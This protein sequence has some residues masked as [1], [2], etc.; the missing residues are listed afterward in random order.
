VFFEGPPT[1]NGKPGIHHVWARIY[2]DLFCRFHAMSGFRVNRRAGWDT[3]GLPVE[4]EVEKALGIKSKREVHQ[5]GIGPFVE[6]C[7]ASVRQYVDE[8]MELTR[9][10]G[11]WVDFET[12]YWTLDPNYVQSVWWHLRQLF[13]QGLLYEGRKGVPYC[14]RCETA[15]SS[16]ELAQPGAYREIEDPSVYVRLKLLDQD[17]I[18]PVAREL[19][20]WTTTPWTLPSNTGVAV[21]PDL[22][23]VVSNG[24]V[25]AE[26]RRVAVLGED[27]PVDRILAGSELIGL[28][29]ERPLAMVPV[30]PDSRGWRVV[31]ADFVSADDGTG[32]VH[33]APAFG[34]EDR[35]VGE[36]TGLP[37]LDPMG[38]DGC[39]KPGTG[40]LAG[41]PVRDANQAVVEELERTDRLFRLVPYL[42]SY[43][44]CWRCG[45]PLVYWSKSSWFVATSSRKEDLIAANATVNWRPEHIGT[46]R[47]GEWL[48]NNID[49]ALSRN[50][51]W[52]TP[53]PIWRCS[54]GHTYCVESLA[55]LSKLAGRDVTD[56]DPH[57]PVIDE[58]EFPCPSCA[59][60][61]HRVEEVIDAWFDS[62]S[63]PAAQLGY[64][65]VEGS[66]DALRLPADFI[67]E[68]I[69]QTRGWFYS[70]LAVN[71]LVH[72]VAPYKTVLCLGHIVDEAGRKMSKSV[73]NV[74]DPWS[75]LSSRGADPLRW[76]MFHQGSPWTP[77]RTSLGAIDSSTQGMPI[78]L[79][80]LWKFFTTYAGLN[81]FDLADPAIP[82]P[83]DRPELDRWALSRL[84]SAVI[85]ITDR[86]SDYRPLEAA[87]ALFE[88]VDDLSNWYVR[89]SRRRFWR[90]DPSLG[91]EDSL[92]AQATL[93]ECL[94]NVT[95][96]LA[97]FCPFLADAIYLD[98]ARFQADP[99]S[100]LASVHLAD[101]PK[102]RP[103]LIDTELEARM[104]QARRLASLGRSAR[105]QAR[106]KVRQPLS[107][108]L[109]VLGRE[110]VDVLSEVV[111]DELNVDRIE[112][113]EKA[114][115]FM[116][117]EVVPNFA[118][119]GP[120]LGRSVGLVRPALVQLKS[121]DLTEL[122]AGRSI[123]L[124][125]AD[126]A[127]VELSPED[128]EIRV[129]P[130]E[131]FEVAYLGAEAVVLDLTLDEDLIRRGEVREM[132]RQVQDLRKQAGFEVSDRIQLTL[133]GLTDLGQSTEEVAR[134]VLATRVV[135]HPELPAA[136]SAE[137]PDAC[138]G[139]LKLDDR[140]VAAFIER[141]PPAGHERL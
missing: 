70:L 86:L 42:H 121:E 52:G 9:R 1:A 120:R 50:R 55:E 36:V 59:A 4:V 100:T 106:I 88:L 138:V 105:A 112:V 87:Q 139:R 38:E 10:I 65:H 114:A 74:I 47:F 43:P 29:Y 6:R 85:Q 122:Q 32:L 16:H 26:A 46:G 68:G 84:N 27:A 20:I 77:T 11:F 71:R 3:H 118:R 17:G 98:L 107:R 15:L 137:G 40:F 115:E 111:C 130:K 76:W 95:L 73:G 92:A 14:P 19:L 82:A 60:P 5:L 133:W 54:A 22:D 33:L 108:A 83:A 140:E 67:A 117:F 18:E 51:F 99:A 35:R 128:V 93:G 39:F 119:L 45:T 69:D 90:T 28:E 134:E 25:V 48:E 80:N 81:S 57:R 78:T 96:L 56:L 37:V 101:W 116:N 64:P 61:A 66:A 23:Y 129:R 53:L 103:D 97:P 44:H 123:P 124:V 126:G 109:V 62:G 113:V 75:I 49:W 30:P 141:V 94:F 31:G 131:G 125:L 89:R 2:K 12:A 24:V 132:I 104:A 34:E 13:D 127:E 21:N 7:R 136:L 41:V 63:M 110:S 91:P 102:G 58:V 8:W 72:G 79:W 135:V